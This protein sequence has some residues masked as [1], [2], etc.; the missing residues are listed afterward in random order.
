[1]SKLIQGSSDWLEFRKTK[2][3]GTDASVI[4]GCN[5][6]RTPYQL[7]RQK[8]DLDPP[9]VENEAMR[10]GTLLEGPA[11][12]WFIKETRIHCE[13]KVV[14]K[15]FMMASLDG[16]SSDQR[17]VVEIKCGS[18]AF[19]QAEAGEIN[20]MYICQMMHQMHCAD[21]DQCLYVA[22]NG[23]KGIIIPVERDQNFINEMIEKEKEFYECLIS[24]TPP[25]MTKGDYQEKNDLEWKN[26]CDQ[27][28]IA[29]QQLKQ[30][31]ILE[32]NLKEQLIALAGS[33][34]TMGHGI[35]L[36]KIVKKGAIDY[37]AIPEIQE[38]DIEKYRKKPTE[39]WKVYF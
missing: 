19:S 3:T 12:E 17:F 24:F 16:L 11:R 5:P 1:M 18:K 9:E 7:W 27:Y 32:K 14:F 6:W 28:R 21:V 20:P 35:K 15:D 22:F 31:E 10:R 38:L 29:Q 25:Q 37:S 26:L 23:E 39:Y 34:P 33:Q 8:M 36:S 4:I 2:I 30:A 13:P